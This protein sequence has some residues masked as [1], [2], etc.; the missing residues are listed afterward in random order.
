[1]GAGTLGSGRK[2]TALLVATITVVV[3]VGISGTFLY[4]SMMRF[5]G[6]AHH[7][8]RLQAFFLAEAGLAEAIKSLNAGGSG[9][10]G[11]Q[12]SPISWQGGQY[13]T[14]A[15]LNADSSY[16]VVST[17]IFRGQT[18]SIASAVKRVQ[19]P[20]FNM[21]L[22]A[23][24]WVQM[25]SNAYTD[26]YNSDLGP[27]N[28]SNNYKGSFYH[29]AD[30]DV[31]SNGSVTLE[32]NAKI[33]GDV[34]IGPGGTTSIN[35]NAYVSGST[36]YG[37][38][39]VVL[40]P[41][42]LPAGYTTWGNGGFGQA[43]SI[44]SNNSYTLPSGSYYFTSFHLDS[45]VVWTVQG[46]ATIV[47]DYFKLDSN[48][49]FRIDATGG[50]VKLYGTGHFEINSNVQVNNL[51]QKAKNFQVCLTTDNIANP[52]L[53]VGLHSN[54]ASYMTVYAPSAYIVYSS[55]SGVWGAMVG[56][57]I[58]MNSNAAFHFDESLRNIL[59][60][61]GNFAVVAWRRVR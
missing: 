44:S 10:V 48:V 37:T 58:L 15:T 45:N 17:G 61:T 56:R 29:N 53:Q 43:V 2:G 36:I 60:G 9:A 20:L 26:S 25:D 18:R 19:A 30:G 3:V 23:D 55:N 11:S 40:P 28:A 57:R 38:S 4:T 8:D 34:W 12:A 46:P 51:S 16:A 32:S 5:G 33:F 54:T 39:K 41:V 50:E 24:E 27:Y 1:M 59:A 21:A 22:F 7:I 14:T 31:G 13:W 47:V 49:E 42:T 52:L 6:M 35:K